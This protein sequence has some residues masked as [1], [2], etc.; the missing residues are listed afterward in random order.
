MKMSNRY[1]EHMKIFSVSLM[2]PSHVYGKLDQPVIGSD[3][4]EL[5]LMLP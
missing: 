5:L 2:A 1:A 4:Q 3:R